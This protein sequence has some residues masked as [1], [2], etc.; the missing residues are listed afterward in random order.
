MRSLLPF[1]A[2]TLCFV[3]CAPSTPAVGIYQSLVDAG[4]MAPAADGVQAIS[5]EH[6]TAGH[7][8][9]LDC[10]WTGGTVQSCSVPCK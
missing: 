10:M 8:A 6:A 7:P 9:W 1:R 4:C 5:D 3:A 2:I